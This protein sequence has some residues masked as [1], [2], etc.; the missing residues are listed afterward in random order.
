MAGSAC[1]GGKIKLNGMS[2]KPSREI[3]TGDIIEISTSGLV[4]KIKVLELLNNRVGAPKVPEYMED[5]TPLED[6]E[7]AKLVRQTN[8]EKRDRGL[9]RPTKRD[10]RD[11]EALKKYLM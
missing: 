7:Q 11:I 10:R 2:V 8:Y 6:I 5:L 4:K 3:K 9:G 1:H